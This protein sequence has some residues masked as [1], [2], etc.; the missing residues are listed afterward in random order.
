MSRKIGLAS[1]GLIGVLAAASTFATLASA[2]AEHPDRTPGKDRTPAKAVR[3][4]GAAALSHTGMATTPPRDSVNTGTRESVSFTANLRAGA[5]ALGPSNCTPVDCSRYLLRTQNPGGDELKIRIQWASPDPATPPSSQDFDMAVFQCTTLAGTSCNTT[6]GTSGNGGTNFEQV[7]FVPQAN[8]LY[9]VIIVH[10]AV[11]VPQNISGTAQLVD[12]PPFTQAIR[13]GPSILAS[14]L[15]FSPNGFVQ[16]LGSGG[17]RAGQAPNGFGTT[18]ATETVR[19]GEPSIRA[20]QL[21]NVYPSG[22]RGVP[23]GVDVWRFGPQALCPR[24]TF[25]FDEEFPTSNVTDGNPAT[26]PD[27]TDGYVWLGQPDNLFFGPAEDAD[28]G[29]PDEGGG[30]IETAVGFPASST[31]AAPP[32][33]AMVSLTLANITSSM[34]AD[35]GNE[36]TPS[37]SA[38][39]TVPLDDRQWIEA[40]GANT[41]YLY[42]RTLA[43]PGLTGLILNKSINGGATYLTGTTIPSLAGYTPGWIDVDQTPNSDGSVTIYLSG[44]NSSELVVFRC[45]DPT[46]TMVNTEAEPIVCSQ[47]NLVN[48][49]MSHGHI[50]DPVTVGTN[51]DVYAVWS[52]NRDIF[53]AHSTDKSAN[54]AKPVRITNAAA[55]NPANPNN[56]EPTFNFFPWV[57]A[58]TNGRVGVVWYGSTTTTINTDNN[59]EWLAYYAFSKDAKAATP[60]YFWTTASDHYIHHENASQAGLSTDENVNRNLIDFFEVAMDPRDGAAVIA[61]A[62]DNNDVDGGTYY[63]RQ[64]R[65]PGLLAGKTI[66]QRDC[67][68]LPILRDPEVHDQAG[69]VQAA[70]TTENPDPTLDLDDIDFTWVDVGGVTYIQADIY[71]VNLPAEP[72]EKQYRAYFAINTDRGLFDKGNE[73]FIQVATDLPTPVFIPLF[74]L[75]VVERQPDG[76]QDEVVTSENIDADQVVDPFLEGSPGIVRLRVRADRLDYSFTAGGTPVN[77]GSDPPSVNELVI[78]LRG[79]SYDRPPL[80][81]IQTDETRGGSFIILNSCKDGGNGTLIGPCPVT[82]PLISPQVSTFGGWHG[83][84]TPDGGQAFAMHVQPRNQA[85]TGQR[86]FMELQ[87]KGTSVRYDYFTNP[88]GG[89][90]EV[91]IDGV[92][93]GVID[94]YR[95]SADE[96]GHQDLVAASRTYTVAPQTGPHTLRLVARADLNAYP[97]NVAYVTGFSASGGLV[98]NALFRDDA[99]V[100]SPNVVFKGKTIEH[101]I[102]ADANTVRVAAAI[103]PAMEKWVAKGALKVEILGP[104][105]ALIGSSLQ[106]K[107][108]E[109]VAAAVAAPGKYTIRIRNNSDRAIAY[110]SAFVRTQRAF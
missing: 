86:P 93:R 44:Q 51:G 68:K 85:P 29:S 82:S 45:T 60:T 33:L 96:S 72:Q 79:R 50:F 52:N 16:T 2:R 32:I 61:F 20:D 90:V 27:P 57:V 84:A 14:G 80:L 6:V 95:A 47:P 25:H 65:G 22:I 24:F 56:V 15:R 67:P 12:P 40:F 109:A 92:S 59:G 64:T 62:G 19:D 103:E 108:S 43:A 3:T 91:F 46:P 49:T 78:G 102:V 9:E 73:Y 75:G 74:E 4:A 55:G 17:G 41:V 42:Y 70:F 104:Q 100:L 28:V 38:S 76:L 83:H 48:D 7:R 13:K 53:I 63:T 5:N 99:R 1:F 98:G 97:R 71:V 18:R 81:Q 89:K 110:G 31:L 21:G 10:F 58:G 37:V 87:F 54:W 106:T 88:R 30:D 11:T 107:V 101:A 36:W 23:A 94:Q 105:G 66:Q 69:D 35:R 26:L 39:A 8:V 77:G 34:S